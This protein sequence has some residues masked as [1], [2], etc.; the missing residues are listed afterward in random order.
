MQT[1]EKILFQA[2]LN[3]APLEE[4][5]KD[6]AAFL[7]NPLILFDTFYCIVAS[8]PKEDILDPEWRKAVE[9]SVCSPEFISEL[10]NIR[11]LHNAEDN[12]DC[13]EVA[14]RH[15]PYRKLVA[16]IRIE[17]ESGISIITIACKKPFSADIH[18]QMI[19]LSKSLSV[20]FQKKEARTEMPITDE[21]LY[22]T[23]LNEQNMAPDH[24]K[25]R[26][27]KLNYSLAKDCDNY[28]LL[29]NL[30]ESGK[31]RS[32]ADPGAKDAIHFMKKIKGIFSRV[33]FLYYQNHLLTFLDEKEL[34]KI[35]A[36]EALLLT[37]DFKCAVSRPCNSYERIFYAHEEC[38]QA[39][40]LGPYLTE[41]PIYRYADLHFFKGLFMIH[42]LDGLNEYK[43]PIIRQ[44]ETEE[45]LSQ[46][47]CETLRI[48]L[49]ENKSLQKT[50]EHLYIHRNTVYARLKKIEEALGIDLQ[51]EQLCTRLNIS[52][53]LYRF[54]QKRVQ[55]IEE[56]EAVYNNELSA[57]G[58][59]T[60]SFY[61]NYL[62][63]IPPAD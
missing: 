24:I 53:K 49:A 7:G 31:C 58:V 43:H 61:A 23:R 42:P 60:K 17:G 47:D 41:S 15:S 1:L 4:L 8:S 21:A 46:E 11:Y 6:A 55:E 10:P 12:S 62:M 36:L 39:M 37:Y 38:K 54:F 29:F 56:K 51:D 48:Y 13:Y 19:L 63:T 33:I 40:L 59:D 18:Q 52:F 50:A 32:E 3:Q 26:F 28:V 20:F 30:Q 57:A 27:E 44:F 45:T 25:R 9:N 22:F 14:C 34:E 5:L 16:P 2:L 35:D